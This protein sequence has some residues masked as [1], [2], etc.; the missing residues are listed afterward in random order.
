MRV[1]LDFDRIMDKTQ[2]HQYMKTQLHL[3]D[4]Y[5]G[6]LDALYDCLTSSNVITHIHIRHMQHLQSALGEYAQILIEVL[7]NAGISV[8]IDK[9]QE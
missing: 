4:Y 7:Q 1:E 2:L 9:E 8:E 3:P 6:N 5:G